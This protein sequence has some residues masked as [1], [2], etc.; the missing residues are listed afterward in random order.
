MF[1]M[2]IETQRE[3]LR[4][5][6][7][8]LPDSE[9]LSALRY[10]QF[11]ESVG[12]DPLVAAFMNAPIDDEPLDSDD[13]ERIAEARTESTGEDWIAVRKRLLENTPA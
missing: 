8:A 13:L 11:L 10:V 1:A 12:G 2:T 6:V 9:V 5:I 4:K 3:A 7:D